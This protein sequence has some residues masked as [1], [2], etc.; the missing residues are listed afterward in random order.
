MNFSTM[1]NSPSCKI[2]RKVELLYSLIWKMS[3][4]Q[5]KNFL[6][7]LEDFKEN[8]DEKK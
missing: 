5:R 1:N 8:V 6:Q 7:Y 2:P 4:D 3:K